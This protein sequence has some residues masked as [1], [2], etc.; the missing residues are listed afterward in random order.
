MPV[1]LML[2]QTHSLLIFNRLLKVSCRV[3]RQEKYR[4]E[5]QTGMEKDRLF[6]FAD[7]IILF[8]KD[9]IDYARKHLYIVRTFSQV[10]G[11]KIDMHMP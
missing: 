5:I 6:Q 3:I 11:Y 7:G 1:S 10:A 9:P 4:K 8:L 2:H